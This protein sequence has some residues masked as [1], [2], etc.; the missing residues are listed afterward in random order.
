MTLTESKS[1]TY[2]FLILSAV[3][4]LALSFIFPIQIK[5][6][7]L[8]IGS[9]IFL[10]GVY[11]YR[12]GKRVDSLFLIFAFFYLLY[13]LSAP[14]SYLFFDIYF[15]RYPFSEGTLRKFGEV[16]AIGLLGIILSIL[17][18]DFFFKPNIRDP[19]INKGSYIY[20]T[21][22][23]YLPYIFAI[24]ASILTLQDLAFANTE[25]IV[26]KGAYAHSQ[27]DAYFSFFALPT[28]C[29][30]VYLFCASRSL[31]N[32]GS[33]PIFLICLSPIILQNLAFG[34]RSALLSILV[35]WFFSY[36]SFNKWR[37]KF[38]Y[39]VPLILL[40]FSLTFAYSARSWLPGYLFG[41]TD[42]RGVKGETFTNNLNP[43]NSEFHSGS[44]NFLTYINDPGVFKEE[45]TYIDSV[46]HIVPRWAL[47]FEK[48]TEISIKFNRTYHD[49]LEARNVR[50]GFSSWVEGYL[51][52]KS[53]GVFLYFLFITFI[54]LSLD[55]LRFNST[56]LIF[57]FIPIVLAPLFIKF[58]RS[59]LASFFGYS[60]ENI[61]VLLIYTLILALLFQPK[62]NRSK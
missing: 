7:L 46:L 53:F 42:W 58:N 55:R 1:L 60:F 10:F 29:F 2:M 13:G 26:K 25:D 14:L 61:V 15:S 21:S 24:F 39:L 34:E 44:G 62:L 37:I 36:T 23:H 16:Y 11:I 32:K 33:L 54:A 17:I 6:I 49:E 43:A 31:T 5:Y 45:F 50:V 27:G 40:V 28:A 48:E 19:E 22:R 41:L 4:F 56:N 57:S 47:P 38:K 52:G 12:L 3:F 35:V 20:I 30:S 8:T 9:L 51:N 59:S 18:T